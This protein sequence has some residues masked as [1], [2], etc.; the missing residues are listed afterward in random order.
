[1]KQRP[2]HTFSHQGDITMTD[3]ITRWR[4]EHANFAKLMDLLESELDVFHEGES[5]NYELMLAIAYY[6]IHYP[7]TLHHPREDLAFEILAERDKGATAL[8]RELS[9]QHARI[10]KDG[11]AL[12]AELDGIVDGTIASRE[13]VENAGRRYIENFRRHM[14]DEDIKVIPLAAR[15]LRPADWS[16]INAKVR[17]IEDPIF[18]K[19]SE[20][21]YAALR[22]HIERERA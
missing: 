7:D 19:G 16:A 18:G 13:R 5:P 10:R 6:M 12:V 15:L 14:Q 2:R 8:T 22:E 3:T 9:Q 21:R 20:Q 11:E 4:A 17:H 1:M